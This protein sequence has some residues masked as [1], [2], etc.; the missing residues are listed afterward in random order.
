MQYDGDMVAAITDAWDR[1]QAD[2]LDTETATDDDYRLLDAFLDELEAGEVRAAE[3]TDDGWETKPWVKQGILLNFGLRETES[4]EYGGVTFYD[5][6]PLRDTDD[7]ADRGTRVTPPASALRR[8][9]YAGA[10]AIFMSPNYINIGAYVDDGALVDS[11]TTVGS[12]AQ[13]GE[14]V[15][16]GANTLVGGVLEPVEDDPVIIEDNARIGGGSRIT[17]GFRV[18]ENT[19]VAE[20]TLLTPRIPVYDLVEDEVLYGELPA[21]RRAFQR[22]APSSV[23]DHNLF[24]DQVYK[25]IAVAMDVDEDTYDTVKQEDTLRA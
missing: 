13:I 7:L 14:D 18:G 15:K 12:C 23:S 25:P 8:G 21:D 1:Y 19:V 17:S 16:L 20:N 22:A 9:S 10:D 24:D 2:A 3:Q 4:Q 5:K 6:F 11:H